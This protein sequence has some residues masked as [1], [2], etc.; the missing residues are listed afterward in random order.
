MTAAEIASIRVSDP[1]IAAWAFRHVDDVRDEMRGH[2]WPRL[3][4]AVDAVA[5]GSV[6]YSERDS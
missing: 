3:R 4:T 2:I 1:E 5:G 6:R